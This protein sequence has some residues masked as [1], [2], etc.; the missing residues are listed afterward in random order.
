MLNLKNLLN[1]Q[2][3]TWIVVAAHWLSRFKSLVNWLASHSILN[4]TIYLELWQLIKWHSAIAPWCPELLEVCD[5][6]SWLCW[7]TLLH[8]TG[9]KPASPLEIFDSEPDIAAW[10]ITHHWDPLIL[11]TRWRDVTELDWAEQ[12]WSL[13]AGSHS[14]G[15]TTAS[16][17]PAGRGGPGRQSWV[18]AGPHYSLQ[19]SSSTVFHIYISDPVP[20]H[21]TSGKWYYWNNHH[22]I[23]T[24][25]NT[26][27][28]LPLVHSVKEL[29]VPL[30]R[31]LFVTFLQFL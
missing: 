30:S 14:T 25:R 8:D 20:P 2:Y 6:I 12:S 23:L 29:F 17:S 28:F 15:S 21:R 1:C 18:V 22:C 26:S 27:R 19:H 4:I 10:W 3:F 5:K 16:F 11:T 31:Y 7:N 24:S 9:D 13:L